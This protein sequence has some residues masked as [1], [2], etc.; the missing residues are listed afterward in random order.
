[1]RISSQEAEKIMTASG[2]CD[3]KGILS[4][5]KKENCQGFYLEF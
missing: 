4:L 3:I 5:S 1:M 2:G